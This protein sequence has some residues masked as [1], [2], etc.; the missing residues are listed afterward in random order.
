L[1]L[2]VTTAAFLCV[3]DLHGSGTRLP[4]VGFEAENVRGWEGP[5][6][7]VTLLRLISGPAR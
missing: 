2:P 3:K 7:G 4:P 5:H 6:S 1:F